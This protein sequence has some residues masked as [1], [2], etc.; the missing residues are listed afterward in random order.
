[1]ALEGKNHNFACPCL[2]FFYYLK[3]DGIR[4]DCPGLLILQ[5]PSGIVDHAE[6][7]QFSSVSQ[8]CPPLCNPMDCSVPGFPVHYQLPELAQT[9]VHHVGDAISNHLILCCPL[10]LLPSIFPS[11]RVFSMSQL[12]TS[13]DQ[14]LELQLKHQTF[15]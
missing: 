9:H 3:I 11:I 10:L 15:Q 5:S 8:S 4:L 12:F 6:K 13:G 2:F 7:D 1:M 14:V